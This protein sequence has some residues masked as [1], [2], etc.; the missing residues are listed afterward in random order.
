[1]LDVKIKH[2]FKLSVKFFHWP[3]W[4]IYSMKKNCPANKVSCKKYKRKF[5][6][7]LTRVNAANRNIITQFLF[8]EFSDNVNIP[9]NKVLMIPITHI[10]KYLYWYNTNVSTFLISDPV[11]KRSLKS[12]FCLQLSDGIYETITTTTTTIINNDY[13]QPCTR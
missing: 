5:I 6:N 4:H 10:W 12:K 9:T 3:T 7:I 13:L 8:K 2:A 11:N 1:M